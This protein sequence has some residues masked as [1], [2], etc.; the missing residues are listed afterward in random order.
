VKNTLKSNCNHTSKLVKKKK[1]K[2]RNERFGQKPKNKGKKRLIP[3]FMRDKNI[4]V[5]IDARRKKRIL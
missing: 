4:S 2:R 5:R 1:G 3:Y